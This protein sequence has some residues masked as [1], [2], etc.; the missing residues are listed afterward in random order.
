MS[1]SIKLNLFYNIRKFYYDRKK[2]TE[3]DKQLIELKKRNMTINDTDLTYAKRI[4]KRNNYY[5]LINGYKEA[6][7]E[8]KYKEG[9]DLK[10]IYTLYKFNKNISRLFF[11]YLLTIESLIKTV[12]SQKYGHA[13]LN[14]RKF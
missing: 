1:Y 13:L 12:I 3:I 4:L 6:F 10:E 2:Y 9:T 14:K 5:N 8:D 11:G 7:L